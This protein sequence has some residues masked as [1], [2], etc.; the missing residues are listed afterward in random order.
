MSADAVLRL[1]ARREGRRITGVSVNNPRPQAAQGLAGLGV[2]EALK[3]VATFPTLCP[4]AQTIAATAACVAAG[5]PNLQRAEPWAEERALAAET[6]QD[7]LWRLML[8]WPRLFGHPPRTDR[9]AK[10][11][12]RLAQIGD[13]REAYELGGDLLDLVA[14]ELLTGFF[15]TTREPS[16]LREFV[17]RARRG[18]TIGAALAD[19]IEMG[20]STPEGEAVP[21]LPM[22]AAGAWANELGGIPSAAFCAAPTLFGRAHETGVLARHADSMMVRNLLTHRHRIAARLFARVVDLSDSASRLRHPLAGDM[23]VMIDT[24]PLGDG[25]GLACVETP[26]GLLMHAVRLDGE[27]I[28]EYAIVSPTEWNFHAQ[29]P[30][31]REGCGW[32]AASDEAAMLRLQVLALSL[33]PCMAYE[34]AIEDVA[35]A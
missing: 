31:V 9:F 32:E 29:G 28:A 15:R 13:A 35:G 17:E 5:A 8:D 26:R 11:H 30:F 20:S 22:L 19:L 21:L 2:D 16:G 12:H 10:L 23:P 14:V 24:A 7:H 4:R 27:R 33:D 3:L 6:A 1:V 18:G 34:I 25:A